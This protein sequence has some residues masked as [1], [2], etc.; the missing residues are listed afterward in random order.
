MALTNKT[1]KLTLLMCISSSFLSRSFYPSH[2]PQTAF[3]DAPDI[4]SPIFPAF[5]YVDT[6]K[7]QGQSKGS[8]AK[9]KTTFR[10]VSR[11]SEVQ[12]LALAH[13]IDSR[14][15]LKRCD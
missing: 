13:V 6:T 4:K 7:K 10:S 5:A 3:G 14:W 1:A 2:V 15:P 8:W 9:K 12:A 11:Y